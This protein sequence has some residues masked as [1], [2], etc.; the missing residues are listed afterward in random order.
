VCQ[1]D[2]QSQEQSQ[3]QQQQQQSSPPKNQPFV[4]TANTKLNPFVSV[5][6]SR[7]MLSHLFK[8]EYGRYLPAANTTCNN[9][10]CP[11]LV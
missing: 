9:D 1:Q 2:D 5:H 6:A 7:P 11:W 8:A 10:V 3:Q 4:S